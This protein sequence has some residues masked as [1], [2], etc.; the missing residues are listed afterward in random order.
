MNRT[1]FFSRIYF[2]FIGIAIL[3][4]PFTSFLYF[5]ITPLL[6][7]FWII[8]GDW[9]N[10]WKRLNE[11][12]TL[13]ITAAFVLFWFMNVVGLLYSNDLIKGLMRTI[14]K[15]PFLVYPLLFFTSDKS[16]FTK[17]KFHLLFRVFLYSTS[18][19]LIIC[20]CNALTQSILTGKTYHLYYIYFS[21]LFGH[22]SY[23]ALKVSIAFC[24]AFCFFNSTKKW[25]YL[26]MM[27]FFGISIYFFQS[28]TGTF[29]FLLTLFLTLCYYLCTH[30]KNY[31]YI[32]GIFIITALFALA[33]VKFFPGR[34]DSY[35]KGTYLK[36]KDKFDILESRSEIWTACFKIAIENK[37]TGI[38]SG[39]DYIGYLDENEKELFGENK[40][41]LNAHNQYLQTFLDHGVFG[42]LILFFLII[43]SFYLAVKTKNYLLFMLLL[44]LTINIIFES[45]LERSNGIF[46]F[47]LFFI[48]FLPFNSIYENNY[49]DKSQ[50]T[51]PKHY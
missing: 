9:N 15:L 19:M 46:T 4:I 13:L 27:I 44:A 14:D 51:F 47:C 22:P 11:D 29:V 8:E 30:K 1:L 20:W 2:L 50:K 28:R 35:I 12:S 48:L 21:N 49:G 10:K 33:L 16:Y 31:P 23:C 7:I 41:F 17:E 24:I 43:Y 37:F 34:M 32:I 26:S 3:S 36:E 42:L 18:L 39:Y 40:L 25:I 5:L 45:M 38:G 6:L